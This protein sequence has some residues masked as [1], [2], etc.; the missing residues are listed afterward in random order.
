MPLGL[1]LAPE[2]PKPIPSDIL[3]LI[4]PH[5]LP[6]LLNSSTNWGASIQ[7][8]KPVRAIL[9]QTTTPAITTT[10]LWAV[11]HVRSS[12]ESLVGWFCGRRERG[13]KANACASG[14]SLWADSALFR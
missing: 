14:P 11:K 6:V 13:I 10:R 3:T 8:H 2:A 1:A 12:L 4:R 5:L 7:T 9:I